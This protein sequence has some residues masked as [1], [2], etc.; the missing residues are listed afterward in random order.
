M[1][2]FITVTMLSA[3][4]VACATTSNPDAAST[5]PA[6]KTRGGDVDEGIRALR[7]GRY[8]EAIREFNR[9][10]SRA[11]ESAALHLLAGTA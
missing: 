9:A 8:D 7:A 3:M 6:A 10:L 11:P 5:A 1:I 2:R 4:L